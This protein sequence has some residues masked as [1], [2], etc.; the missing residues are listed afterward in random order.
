MPEPPL[1]KPPKPLLLPSA[2][3]QNIL[4]DSDLSHARHSSHASQISDNDHTTNLSSSLSTKQ[5][6]PWGLR[7]TLLLPL[8]SYPL[9]IFINLVLRL[10]W[11][12]K[13]SSHLHTHTS[14]AVVIFWIEVAELLRRWIWVFFRVEWECVRR[15]KEKSKFAPEMEDLEIDSIVIEGRQPM[16]GELT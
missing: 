6:R 3:R 12:I 5:H 7:S 11:S 1:N 13:L 8:P 15:N 10:T 4:F 16:D 2:H 9:A 14:G